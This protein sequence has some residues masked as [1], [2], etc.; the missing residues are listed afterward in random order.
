[1]Y[2][3]QRKQLTT[4][5][6]KIVY[7]VVVFRDSVAY[8]PYAYEPIPY[9]TL[10]GQKPFLARGKSEKNTARLRLHYWKR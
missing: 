9:E 3:K 10:N 6:N 7:K 4:K 8:T 2:T 5:T 1:M